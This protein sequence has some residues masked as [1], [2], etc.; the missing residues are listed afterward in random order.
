LK[1]NLFDLVIF[2]EASQ[3]RIEDT[4][5]ALIRGRIRIISG[6]EQQMPPSSY[7]TSSDFLIDTDEEDGNNIPI[8]SQ[9]YRDA[10]QDL[11]NKESLLEFASVLKYEDVYL[12]IHYRSRHPLLIAFS[13]AAFYGNRLNPLPAKT[14]Y[15]PI[16]YINVDGRYENQTNIPEAK[17][18]ISIL[19]NHITQKPDGTYPTVG[20]A[21]FNIYQRNLIID[22]IKKESKV[23]PNFG[24]KIEHLYDDG[25]FIKNLENIQG[26]ERDI[27]I[28][29]TTFGLN[30]NKDF[31]ER[32]G[33]L[34]IS[35]KGHRLLNVII[36]RAKF[37]VYICTS[38]PIQYI[39]K[40]REYL[41]NSG[42]IGRG[43]LYAYL[44]YARAIEENDVELVN[45]ILNQL[46]EKCI[47]KK[48]FDED[49]FLFGTESPFEE[50][51]VNLLIKN[52]IP[53]ERVELQYKCG[54]FRIDIVIKSNQTGKPIIAI[55]C[56][57]ATY[58]SSNEAYLWD[59][60][61]QK[62]LE[63][64]GFKFIRIWSTDWWLSPN[65]E[66]MKIVNYIQSIDHEE[67]VVSETIL[68]MNLA[69]TLLDKIV[70]SDRLVTKSSIVS[71]ENIKSS[72]KIRIRFSSTPQTSLFIKDGI[73]VVYEKAPIAAALFG[74]R[75]G[76][77]C[78]IEFSGELF[79]ILDISEN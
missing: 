51:V 49:D 19:K 27:I 8:E 73:Q 31:H 29:S 69:D 57:G 50:E 66:I 44:S 10:I 38:F 26:D 62:H 33:P 20:I 76:D 45:S 13:N 4:Y 25:L 71:V 79:K 12:R 52:G 70:F 61:R 42:N 18:V 41:Q 39:Q 64:Y 74:K 54:G 30:N 46:V 16:R 40:Y 43:V 36:T 58:H 37:K 77:V 72:K 22:E 63:E 9:M 7:F 60:F 24:N 35:T 56:D 78:E 21:T 28:I 17:Q 15:K 47:T 32:F 14:D 53:K 2:D 23:D 68:D 67:V 65:T 11:A 34:N 55:E 75:I 48:T 1:E 5:S 59:I 3:L 6:D